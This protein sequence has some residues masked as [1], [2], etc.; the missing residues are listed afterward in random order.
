MATDDSL[1]VLID[2]DPAVHASLDSLF[3]SVDQPF[4]AF[5]STRDFLEA[6]IP[7]VACC[8]VLDVRLP[9]Q[10]G[11]VFQQELRR[12]QRPV[13]I[14]FITGHGDVPM[15]VEA[16]KAGAIEFL[17][18]PFRDQDILDAVNR[19]LR[20]DR[21][22]RQAAARSSGLRERYRSLTP[23]ERDV[24]GFVAEGLLN[25]EIAARLELSVVTVKVHRAQV[26]RKMGA[27]SVADLVRLA[28][29]LTA[30]V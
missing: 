22:R 28:D 3:R 6:N 14:V 15:S 27:R 29:S 16:M 18:K 13:P 5:A 21:E 30:D 12:L 17:T 25:K 4:R 1:V 23:R 19:G 9:G 20:L 26:M 10:S 11:L 24:M 8:L 7:D 2:D